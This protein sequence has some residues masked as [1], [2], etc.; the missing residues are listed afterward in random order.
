VRPDA[1]HFMV[2]IR[3]ERGDGQHATSS[4]LIPAD[5]MAQSRTVKLAVVRDISEG[6]MQAYERAAELPE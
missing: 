5:L 1:S 6:F 3:I 2:T 4:R